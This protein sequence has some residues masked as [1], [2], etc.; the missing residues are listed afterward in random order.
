[1]GGP[2]PLGYEVVDKKLVIN[3]A[4]ADI[5]RMLFQ[6]YLEVGCVRT[7]KQEVDTTVMD[8]TIG[9]GA[10]SSRGGLYKLLSNPIY[11][12]QIR[13][14]GVCYSGQ[15]VPIID[16]VLWQ[17]VQQRLS[18]QASGKAGRPR[19]TNP[20]LLVGKL[21]D[22][23]GDRLTPNHAIKQGKRYRYYISQNLK[24]GTVEQ[25]KHGW[26]LP[27]QE[28]EQMV[29]QAARAIL[30]D[31]SAM[32]TAL[33]EAGIEAHQL[34]AILNAASD[35]S[36]RISSETNLAEIFTTLI[37]RVELHQDGIRLTLSLISL[38]PDCPITI[39]RMIPMHIKR[40]GVEM[41]LVIEANGGT[42]PRIDI[43]LIKA[44]ARAR[45][46]F[47][48]LS[49]GKVVSI[50]GIASREGIDKGYVSHLMNLAFLAPDIT[51]AII[52]GRQSADLSVHT[53]IKRTKL[54]LEWGQQRSILGFS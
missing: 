24:T 8:G 42:T 18:V 6:R 39:T 16:P 29:M 11:I 27:A 9:E 40:R 44:V 10:R 32:T 31:R 52:A 54:P 51:E 28:T 41:R 17:Q 4:G 53:L 21:F 22:A 38:V 47:D 7:L 20:S 36:K 34:P 37:N 19:K 13:H 25:N 15:H 48:E 5:V 50:S 3:L 33:Q 26:R 23:S 43:S 12:G 35:L 46:W 1:M 45:Q 14:K 30:D 2:V 49:S